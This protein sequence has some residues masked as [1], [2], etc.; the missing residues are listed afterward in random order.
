MEGRL[1]QSRS[2]LKGLSVC[3]EV[4]DLT[5]VSDGYGKSD[6]HLPRFFSV[7]LRLRLSISLNWLIKFQGVRSPFTNAAI[8]FIILQQLD[9]RIVSISLND[10]L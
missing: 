5:A 6:A 1:R 7:S 2:P 8:P 10:F 9:G 3:G 4:G